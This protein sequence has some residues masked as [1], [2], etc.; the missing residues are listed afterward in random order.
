MITQERLRQLLDYSE[1]TGEF[2]WRTNHNSRA[3]AGT[4]AGTPQ[5]GYIAISVDGERVGAHRLAWMYVHGKWPKHHIDHI[6]GNRQNNR[7]T[8]LRDVPQAIN[9]QNQRK[10]YRINTSGYMG[11]SHQRGKWVAQICVEGR[12][13]WLGTFKTPEEAHAVYVKAKEQLHG[14]SL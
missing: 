13:K 4:V 5:N 8:N 1:E 6:D 2:Q 3:K 14:V 9:M 12:R 11:V 10:P 7:I